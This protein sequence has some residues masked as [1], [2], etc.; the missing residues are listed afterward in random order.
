MDASETPS[1]FEP[2]VRL[3]RKHGVEFIVIG[4]RA[5]SLMGSARI[6]YDTD[7][8]YRRSRENLERLADA[9]KEL[10]P[11]LRGAPPDL[12][13]HIDAN[14]LALGSN[15]TFET[16]LGSLDLL[17]Y[18]EP[19]GD[20]EQVEKHAESY[21]FADAPLRVIGLDDLIRVKQLIRRPKDQDSLTHLLAIKRIRDERRPAP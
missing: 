20:F 15:Y 4:G 11:K 12:K 13:F 14:A 19:I 1:Q 21:E 6:T 8:C 10:H 5:E 18:V 17:G 2:I 7:L 3:F 16:E 9:L